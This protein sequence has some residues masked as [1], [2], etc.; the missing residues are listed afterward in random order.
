MENGV[1]TQCGARSETTAQNN[2]LKGDFV[3]PDEQLIS[4]IGNSFAQN[5][6]TSGFLGSGGATLTDKRF[7]YNGNALSANGSK[8]FLQKTKCIVELSEISA[9]SVVHKS[10]M[11]FALWMAAVFQG[12]AIALFVLSLP[13]VGFIFQACMIITIVAGILSIKNTIYVDYRGGSLAFP[14]KLYGFSQ[15]NEFIRQ[16]LIARKNLLARQKN[17]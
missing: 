2:F 15:C 17:P 7:Y 8:S 16:T 14:I 10:K 13:I 1:C 12:L 11:I 6:F 4:M 5:F 9:V 3:E